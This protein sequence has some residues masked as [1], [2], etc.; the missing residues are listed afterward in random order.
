MAETL[1]EPE[2]RVIVRFQD[3]DPF[4]HLNN[5]RYLDY[6]INARKDHLVAAYGFDIY[7]RAKLHPSYGRVDDDGGKTFETTLRRALESGAPFVQVVTWNDWGEGTVVEPS[8]EFGD[9]DL[10]ALQRLRR[11]LVEPGFAPGPDALGLPRRLLIAGSKQARAR[12][13][14]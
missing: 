4:G 2:S 8:L 10:V 6:L 7:E 13:F 11:E 3:C 9:R 14:K 5:S 1:K 12:A